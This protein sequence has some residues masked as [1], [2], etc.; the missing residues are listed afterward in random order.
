M[1]NAQEA[2]FLQYVQ[3]MYNLAMSKGPLIRAWYGIEREF[4]RYHAR[5]KKKAMKKERAM[6]VVQIEHPV[7]D[8]LDQRNDHFAF[9]QNFESELK[10]QKMEVQDENVSYEQFILDFDRKEQNR[11]KAGQGVPLSQKKKSS[12]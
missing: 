7:L 12:S 2:E 1:A 10:T 11:I 5:L 9:Y 8:G 4:E 6:E 3:R